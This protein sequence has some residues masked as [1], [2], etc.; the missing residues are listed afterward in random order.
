MPVINACVSVRHRNVVSFVLECPRSTC[1]YR[2]IS[3]LCG[4]VHT[5]ASTEGNLHIGEGN[6]VTYKR[7]ADFVLFRDSRFLS[8]ICK[9]YALYASW[10]VILQKIYAKSI[11]IFRG[12]FIIVTYPNVL[13]QFLLWVPFPFNCNTCI[14][15]E[16]RDDRKS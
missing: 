16:K 4:L 2:L 13:A 14:L 9:F 12:K 1:L 8:F 11:C 7:A 6:S 15:F 5:R 10:I 3:H